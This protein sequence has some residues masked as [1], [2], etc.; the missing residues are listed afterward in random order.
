[1]KVLITGAAGFLGSHILEVAVKSQHET[2]V[3]V[4][5]T[6][7]TKV[8]DSLGDRVHRHLGDLA[9]LEAVTKACED[10]DLIIH[11]AGRVTEQG[12]YSDF[13]R[14]NVVATA[15]LLTAA[16][17]QRVSQFVFVSSP[18]IFAGDED[19]LNADESIPY[20][21][22][23]INF[24]AKTKCISEQQV[25]AAN[26]LELFTCS[27]RPRGIWGERDYKGFLPKLLTA[28]SQ[29]KL[30]DLSG[31]RSVL[32][33]VCH[34]KNIAEACFR[35]A[36][37]A[38]TT[39]GQAYFI[40]DDETIVVWDWIRQLGDSYRLPPLGP[41][42]NRRIL[43]AAVGLIEGLWHVP[44]LRKNY[45]PPLSRYSL[46]MLSQHTT[47]SV[48]KARKDFGYDPQYSM[49]RSLDDF[50]QWIEA[51]GGLKHYLGRN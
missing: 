14:D 20:P 21:K 11:A 13:Y 26:C 40:T 10:I 23:Y 48:A 30:K 49:S 47:Y 29:G 38:Q 22:T 51:E 16:R 3:I 7:Q 15:N 6:S 17:R 42:V 43:K 35:A 45:S 4:R 8:L 50:K 2:H 5:K 44:Y 27:L 1:M 28:M 31:G 9:D 37:H 18:S 36:A 46:G 39:A 25:L 12:L 32:S 24:Y 34:A 19:H 33:S 41:P